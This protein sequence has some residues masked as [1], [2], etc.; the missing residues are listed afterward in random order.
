M[1][2]S[3]RPGIATT[4]T[5]ARLPLAALPQT[6]LL[7][8]NID[9]IPLLKDA[10]APG[11][12]IQPLRLDPEKGQVVLMATMAPGCRLPIHYHTGTAE[13]YTFSGCWRYA[14]YPPNR[15]PRATTCMS[16]A[17]RC[18][19]STAP[20]TTRR[21]PSCCCGWKA[22]KSNFNDDGTLHGIN[23]AALDP[24]PD[25]HPVGGSGASE[26]PLYP[27]WQC[28]RER[29]LT[30]PQ[31]RGSRRARRLRAPRRVACLN[32]KKRKVQIM[33]AF[34]GARVLELG[35]IYN[36]PYC[37]LLLAQLGADVIKI[38]PPGGEQQ[39]RFRSHQPV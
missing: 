1:T 12:H 27:R 23:D 32:A 13:V 33:S 38:E 37:G 24:V 39:L 3:V 4:T 28:R 16:P 34:D 10:L 14:E 26:R 8:I 22:R 30:S 31:L 15:R 17:A 35:Q 11:I 21:T 36:G 2:V 20:R 6:D 5:G 25:R 19:P 18:T 9:Q 29:G 7:S